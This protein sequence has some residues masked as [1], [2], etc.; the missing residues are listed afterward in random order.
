MIR[1][2]TRYFYVDIPKVPPKYTFRWTRYAIPSNVVYAFNLLNK[3][4]FFF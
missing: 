2:C 4:L 1:P 3:R